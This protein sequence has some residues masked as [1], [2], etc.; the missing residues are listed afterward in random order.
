MKTFLSDPKII[1]FPALQLTT[2]G[3]IS[4]A[5][6][7]FSHLGTVFY[8]LSCPFLRWQ[9]ADLRDFTGNQILQFKLQCLHLVQTFYEVQ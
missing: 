9:A 6:G 2:W 8:L 7:I 5:K 1:K 4:G 3:T